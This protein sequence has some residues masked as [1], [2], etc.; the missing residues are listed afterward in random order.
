MCILFPLLGRTK[1]STFWSSFLWIFIW[2]VNCILGILSFVANIHLS[3]SAYHMCPFVTG[4][5]HSWWRIEL[6]IWWGLHWICWF[7]WERWPFLLY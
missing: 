3:V 5:P 4:L 2:S 7:L 6:E 1:A